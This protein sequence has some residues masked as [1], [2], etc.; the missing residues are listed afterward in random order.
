LLPVIDEQLETASGQV[1]RAD[2]DELTIAFD[3]L[4]S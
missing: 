3:V 4:L 2:L 1:V